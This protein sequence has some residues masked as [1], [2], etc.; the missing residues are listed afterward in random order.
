M[1]AYFSIPVNIKKS[2]GGRFV[3]QSVTRL[4][5]RSLDWLVAISVSHSIGQA[6]SWSDCLVVNQSK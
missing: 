2:L 4:V 1:L 3:A 6:I 5:V